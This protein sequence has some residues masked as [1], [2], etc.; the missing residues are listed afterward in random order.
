[1][2]PSNESVRRKCGH[3]ELEPVTYGTSLGIS[4]ITELGS[5]G[6]TEI[7]LLLGF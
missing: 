2:V 7:V 4:E 1:M 3:V 5:L 6:N